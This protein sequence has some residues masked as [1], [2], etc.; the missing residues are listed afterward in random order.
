[1]A[2][3][4]E[5][6]RILL[7]RATTTAVIPTIPVSNNH[8]DGTWIP[9]D[10][11]TGEAMFNMVDNKGW[12]RTNDGIC[13]IPLINTTGQFIKDIGGNRI[14]TFDFNAGSGGGRHY[15]QSFNDGTNTSSLKMFGG[16]FILETTLGASITGDASGDVYMVG[17]NIIN[18]QATSI[19]FAG[20]TTVSQDA[21]VGLEVM[22]YQQSYAAF[23]PITGGAYLPLSGTG[24]GEMSG[25]VMF[26]A[27]HDYK[28]Y[29]T[30]PSTFESAFGF[31]A[32]S[33][34]SMKF[35]NITL[36]KFTSFTVAHNQA[37]INSDNATFAGI[38]EG[39]DFKAYYT[40]LSLTNKNYVDASDL[41]LQNQINTINSGLKWK[42]SVRAATT[43]NI[44][45]SGAQTID[46]VSII[47]GDRVLVKNQST[48]ANNG[49]YL[50]AA[51]AWTRTTDA[52]TGAEMLQATT[53]IEEGST[54]ADQIWIC[55]TNGPITIGVTSL[56]FAKTSATTYTGSDGIT[57]TGN[58]FTLDNSYFSGAFTLSAGVAT[59][60]NG[61]VTNAML[62]GSIDLTTKV[63]GILP[64]T[65]GG[66]GVNNSTRT[67][68][69]AGNLITTGAFN[70]TF[71]AQATV[72]TT[73]PPVATTLAGKTGTMVANYI[74]YWNDANQIT[75]NANFQFDG[76]AIGIGG[77]PSTGGNMGLHITGV[78]GGA[79]Q[80]KVVGSGAAGNPN[81]FV[82]N[83]TNSCYTQIDAFGSAVGGT[84]AAITKNNMSSLR[85]APGSGGVGMISVEGAFA[86]NLATNSIVRLAVSSAGNFTFFD[87][88]TLN[89]GATTG[90]KVGATGDKLALY[91]ATPIV[92]PSST[93]VTTSG[94]TANTSANIIYAES[95]FTGGVGSTAYSFSDAIK[96]LKTIGILAM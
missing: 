39:S 24:A 19:N 78:S 80:F 63:T 90:V 72:T 33:D 61:Y 18:L 55:T 13:D 38:Q 12:I 85:L 16:R 37:V 86:F 94:F 58:N 52:D 6:A 70:T 22:T 20:I 95:T 84:I 21:T 88:A 75:G 96:H 3:N 83:T 28:I 62:A 32:G 71:A 56:A 27:A 2:L 89:F 10:L 9:T 59:I 49:I 60:A 68:T 11:Y 1:M 23:A 50:C 46:G 42:N 91:G 43:A 40:G 35:T 47:A 82:I 4:V 26:E 48:S 64:G 66:T 41:I 5:D 29:Q 25:N 51:G 17:A 34:L 79:P 44:T 53:S 14:T 8:T 30:E 31:Q 76:T 81:G 93:G 77:A 92:Q 36:N 57:L 87:G 73:L 65:N 54:L 69:I 74:S 45:L 67:I 7:K 15:L